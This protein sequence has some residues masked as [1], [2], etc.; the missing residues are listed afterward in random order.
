MPFKTLRTSVQAVAANDE[1]TVL[2]ESGGNRRYKM[3]HPVFSQR[4][5]K[6]APAVVVIMKNVNPS[7]RQ[8]DLKQTVSVDSV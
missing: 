1:V 4:R 7:C 5:A 3:S 2:F 6:S 8:T